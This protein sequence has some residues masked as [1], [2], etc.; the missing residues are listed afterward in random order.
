MSTPK[1]SKS[2]K[3][4][5]ELEVLKQKKTAIKTE[6]SY[7]TASL[8]NARRA[9]TKA[10]A[11]ILEAKKKYSQAV[12]DQNIFTTRNIT[13]SH[14]KSDVKRAIESKDIELAVVVQEEIEK[15]IIVKKKKEQLEPILARINKL[16]EDVVKIIGEYLPYIVRIELLE[17]VQ[18]TS[19]ILNK[20]S[21]EMMHMF[22]SILC[23]EQH[24]VNLLPPEE[25]IKQIPKIRDEEGQLVRNPAYAPFHNRSNGYAQDKFRIRYILNIAK[26]VNPQ[27]V[28]NII[29]TMR[30]LYNPS[31]K[32]FVKYTTFIRD[33]TAKLNI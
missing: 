6:I 18:K 32:Y 26:E 10:H 14:K 20:M 15:A 8:L 5:K 23:T 13:L 21:L 28:Y 29:K 25:A 19:T 3:V 12:N 33:R 7:N 11:D 9:A 22:L 30:I 17:A 4:K 1:I 27:L 31:K 24:F 16:P 2:E